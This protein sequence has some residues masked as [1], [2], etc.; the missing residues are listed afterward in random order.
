MPTVPAAVSRSEVEPQAAVAVEFEALLPELKRLAQAFSKKC[1]DPDEVMAEILA[2][3]WWN[4]F[5]AAR[6]GIRLTPAQLLFVARRRVRSGRT[7][8]NPESATDVHSI[9]T[10]RMRRSQIHRL[11]EF[12]GKPSKLN[13]KIGRRFTEAI[14]SDQG[15]PAEISRI[16]LDWSALRT[17][18]SDRHNALVDGFALGRSN[19]EMAKRLR[20]SP[21]RITQIMPELR[22]EIQNFFGVALPVEY[23]DCE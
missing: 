12:H 2:F 10:Q 4:Y 7:L 21:A 8:G 11:S 23:W 5:Q 1:S 9:V 16:H 19:T 15:N 14:T 22:R 17:K 20:L 6:K 13:S 18:L 3:S